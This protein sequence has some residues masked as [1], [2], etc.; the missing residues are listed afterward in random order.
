MTKIFV[1]GEA[2]TTGMKLRERLRASDRFE[3]ITLPESDRKAT[4]ARRAALNACDIA[5]LC[6]PDDAAREAVAMIANPHVKVLDASVAHRVA[7][8]WCYGFP[9]LTAGQRQRIAVAQRVSNPGCFATG[10]LALVRPL[11]DAGL[12]S[13]EDP[14]CIN[15]VSGYTGGGRTLIEAFEDGSNTDTIDSPYYLYALNLQHKHLPEVVMHGNLSMQ[16]LFLPSVGRYRQGILVCL[17]LHA[18]MLKLGSHKDAANAVLTVFRK[19]FADNDDIL[20]GEEV[21]NGRLDPEGLNG[22][23]RLE[24]FVL[25]D[26]ER[27]RIVAVARLDNLGKGSSGAAMAN[28]EIMISS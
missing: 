27:R 12:L 17:P 21:E 28:L 5:V 1:D 8:G 25:S 10:A 11:R 6:L 14:L 23:N 4:A 2:G 16:P 20:V 19:H 22:T 24:I 26:P 15:G 13:A 3:I 9:E 7:P 18:R